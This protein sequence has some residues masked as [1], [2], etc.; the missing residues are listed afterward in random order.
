MK[1]EASRKRYPRKL[2][3]PGKY[4]YRLNYTR[5]T[6]DE[7]NWTQGEALSFQHFPSWSFIPGIGNGCNDFHVVEQAKDGFVR[8]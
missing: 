1:D 3:K 7:D 2:C 8:V 5:L 4:Y 6:F